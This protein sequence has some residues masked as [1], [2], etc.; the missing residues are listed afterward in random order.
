MTLRKFGVAKII[1]FTLLFIGGVLLFS[2]AVMALWNGVLVSSVAGVRSISFI[3]ALGILVLSKILFGFGGG[4][5]WRRRGYGGYWN[6]E[7]KEKWTTM[8]PEEKD[9]MKQEW[10]NR[11]RNWGTAEEV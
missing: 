9:R 6:K 3:Q 11:C 10:R 2:W 1:G 5:G 4:R 7:M 8:T